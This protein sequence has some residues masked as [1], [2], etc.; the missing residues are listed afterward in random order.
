MIIDA[1][2]TSCAIPTTGLTPRAHAVIA[3]M[4]IVSLIV[5]TRL[6]RLRQLRAKYAFIWL[7]VG[8][9]LVVLAAWPGLLDAVSNLLG[10]YYPPTTLFIVALLFLLLLAVHFSWELSRLEERTRILTEELALRDTTAPPAGQ[11]EAGGEPA[12]RERRS[13]GPRSTG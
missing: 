2:A 9:F 8:V 3:A 11:I 10:V 6:V 5:I 1:C 12:R 13:A 7:T 4:T